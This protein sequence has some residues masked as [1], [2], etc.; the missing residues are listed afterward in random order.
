MKFKVRGLVFV[1]F[2]AAILSANAALADP[3]NTVTSKSY[4][5]AKIAGIVSSGDS[6]KAPSGAAVSDALAQKQAIQDST[7]YK[8]GKGGS[9][10]AMTSAVTEATNGYVD[11]TAGTNGEA[12]LNL[13]ST[14][15]TTALPA[16]GLNSESSN[17]VT[18][19]VIKQA[20]ANASQVTNFISNQVGTAT[21]KAPSENAVNQ[22]VTLKGVKVNGTPVTI[23]TSDKTVNL[24]A[25]AGAGL[26]TNG[27]ADDEA[28]LV[29]GD[30]V[31]DYVTGQITNLDLGN[32]YQPK[33]SAAD[34]QIG[35]A[36]GT[37]KTATG[38]DHVSITTNGNN[39]EIAVTDITNAGTDVTSNDTGL[40]T[41]AAVYEYVQALV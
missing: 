1:G 39:V 15:M 17:L 3:D 33:T 4:V 12:I 11:V 5:D 35:M 7:D 29:S 8:V 37:W 23:D 9:W 32:T 26:A 36:G 18:E 22:Y 14:K 13:D 16:N 21:D 2:A 20:I 19:G 6:D 34:Y 25:A 10:A 30:Q 28:G 31:A 41:G 38:T 40:T 27:V 24:G